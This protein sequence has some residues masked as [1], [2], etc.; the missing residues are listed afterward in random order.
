MLGAHWQITLSRS[1]A[2]AT[3]RRRD[4]TEIAWSLGWCKGA[5]SGIGLAQSRRGLRTPVSNGELLM[6]EELRESPEVL[7][8]QTDL[9]RG[10]I[11][12]LCKALA[13]VQPNVVVTCGRGSSAYAA[14]FGKHLIERYLGL[15]VAA[16][17][18]S[19]ATIYGRKLHLKGQ[20]FL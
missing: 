2:A 19:I 4:R 15:P 6:L 10:P 18:P 9:L 17:A 8:R 16:A 12:E 13:V 5:K 1:Q 11:S 3:T 7:R 14:G 20:L